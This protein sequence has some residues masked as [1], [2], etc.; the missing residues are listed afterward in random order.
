MPPINAAHLTH[1]LKRWMRP[2]AHRFLRPDWRKFVR[3]GFEDD[4]PFAL[5]DQK[6]RPDQLRDDYGRWADEGG[7]GSRTSSRDG[8]QV[9]GSV[10]YV[11]IAG[12]SSRF[13]VGNIR[14]Y[15]VTYECT[16]GRTFVRQGAGHKF[17]SI[18]IDPFR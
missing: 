8:I 7:S 1:E 4:H 11:C 14:S 13:T 9:A 2:D 6:Y 5:Y 17:P 3:S 18:V 12:S 10:V 15:S 16:G